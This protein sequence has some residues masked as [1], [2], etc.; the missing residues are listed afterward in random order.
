[1]RYCL[2][3]LLF[4][5]M[6][7]PSDGV[8]GDSS[9]GSCEE[10]ARRCAGSAS[11]EVCAAGAWRQ[12]ICV[13]GCS[14]GRCQSSQQNRCS[15]GSARCGDQGR[16]ICQDDGQ[17]WR[18]FP[19]RTNQSCQ[20]GGCIQDEGRCVPGETTCLDEETIGRCDD[21]GENWQQESTCPADSRCQQGRCISPCDRARDN[22]SYQGCAFY[23]VDLPQVSGDADQDQHPFAVVIANPQEDPLEV[24][25][26]GQLGGVVELVEQQT[27]VESLRSAQGGVPRRETVYSEVHDADGSIERIRGSARGIEVPPRGLATLILPSN[28]AGT[29]RQGLTTTFHSEQASRAYRV[30]TT[31]PVTAYQFQ[32]LCCS[33]SFTNDATILMPVGAQGN[34]YYPVAP[35]IFRGQVPGFVSV[36]GGDEAAQVQINLGDKQVELPPGASAPGGILSLELLPYEVLTLFNEAGAAVRSDLTG[37]EVLSDKEVSVFGG[38]VCTFVPENKGY[39]DHLE[40]SMLPVSTWRSEVVASHTHWR[41]NEPGEVNYYR[42]QAAADDTRIRIIPDLDRIDTHGTM[43]PGLPR[44][45]EMMRDGQLELDQGQWCELGT[46]IDFVARANGAIQMVQFMAGSETSVA[47]IDQNAMN[48]R[49]DPA[50]LA[51]PPTEQYRREYTFLAPTTYESNY[52]NLIHRPGTEILLDGQEVDGTTM[53]NANQ[54]PHLVLANQDIGDRVWQM[55]VVEIGPGAHRV[56]SADGDRFGI[57]VYA[58]DR[59]VSYAYAGGMDLAKA[60]GP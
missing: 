58:Y 15:P 21:S 16:E 43:A 49:G 44:C 14:E 30:E 22:R 17:G 13:A 34:H 35:P 28:S 53:G 36:V 2:F 4:L 18:R 40:T 12:E 38:H 47:V 5:G 45:T 52:I 55:S 10:G 1:M 29:R 27:V 23:A 37:I 59:D 24:T 60:A 26:T 8:P 25:V 19:C 48:Q 56:E 57:T 41:G 3:A 32:P 9:P 51:I 46:R 42:I 20:D 50:V 33:H 6:G 39:C 54:L 11:A 7:C 31:L